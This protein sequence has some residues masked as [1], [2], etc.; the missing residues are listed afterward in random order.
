VDPDTVVGRLLQF[1]FVEFDEFVLHIV[2]SLGREFHYEILR[3]SRTWHEYGR[4]RH[5]RKNQTH[6]R[7]EANFSDNHVTVPPMKWGWYTGS[8]SPISMEPPLRRFRARS[9]TTAQEANTFDDYCDRLL[10]RH[11]YAPQ[12]RAERRRRVVVHGDGCN[13]ALRVHYRLN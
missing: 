9:R 5:R 10:S 6:A 2:D 3:A 13:S 1:G 11:Q 12:T 8:R 4:R 7:F